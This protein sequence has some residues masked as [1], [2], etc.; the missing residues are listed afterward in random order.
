MFRFGCAYGELKAL[1]AAFEIPLTIVTPTRWKP[2]VG[3]LKGSDKEASRL[4]ALQLFPD[5]EPAQALLTFLK[6]MTRPPALIDFAKTRPWA[7]AGADV[8][9]EILAL[10]DATI[11]RRRERMELDPFDDALPGKS[12]NAFLILRAWFADPFPSN[13]GAARGEARPKNHTLLENEVKENV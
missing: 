9:F 4:R 2:A 7:N 6:T 10:L 3:L 1:I 12:E 5:G 8:R 13:N 11:I